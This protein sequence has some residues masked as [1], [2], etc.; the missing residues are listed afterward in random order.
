MF[1]IVLFNHKKDFTFNSDNYQYQYQNNDPVNFKIEEETIIRIE[2]KG[3]TQKLHLD[4]NNDN[5]IHLMVFLSVDPDT[6]IDYYPSNGLV[7]Y[8][9]TYDSQL[10]DYLKNYQRRTGKYSLEIENKLTSTEDQKIYLTLFCPFFKNKD[11]EIVQ[12]SLLTQQAVTPIKSTIYF[13]HFD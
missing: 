6:N 9:S 13:N 10:G 11:N 8:Q 4:V 1:Y 5:C 7:H 3:N 2:L 12:V